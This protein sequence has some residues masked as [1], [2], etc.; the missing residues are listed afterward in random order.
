MKLTDIVEKTKQKW[1]VW[2]NKGLAYIA[3][4]L[5]IDI[6]NGSFREKYTRVNDYDHEILREKPGSTM[7][8]TS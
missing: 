1:N 5:A 7:K 6:V 4:S 8:I 2:I 3:K